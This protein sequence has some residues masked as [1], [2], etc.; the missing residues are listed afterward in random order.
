[1][2]ETFM[3]RSLSEIA[4]LNIGPSAD[5]D[6]ACPKLVFVAPGLMGR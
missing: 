6:R 2:V 3:S 5:P 4:G 1:M